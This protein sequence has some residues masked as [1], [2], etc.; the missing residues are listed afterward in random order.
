M[1]VTAETLERAITFATEKHK[2]VVRKGDGRPY[3]LHPMSVLVTLLAIKKSKNALLLAC[4]A[5][6]HDVVEDC[7]VT[8]E[9]IAK[10][11]GH[12]VASLV[13]ELTSD[14]AKIKELGKTE[15]L[16]QK[17][18]RMSSY[19]LCIKLVDRLDNIRDMKTM[20]ASF[21]TKQ[22]DSTTSILASL[23]TNR[24]LTKTHKVLIKMIRKE[25]AQYKLTP[26]A[27]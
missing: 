24:K 7:G 3:I 23:E 20:S 13:D 5:I 25:M 19:G 27:A 4:A 12:Q 16:T 21:R 8:M 2:G 1:N 11:F 22:I 18:I 26:V 6:L 9:E 15:Y 14:N 17:M 10:L